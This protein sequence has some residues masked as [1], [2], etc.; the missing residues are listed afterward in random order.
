MGSVNPKLD[1]VMLLIEEALGAHAKGNI[2]RA[3]YLLDEVLKSDPKNTDALNLRGTMSFLQNDFE[4]AAH[5]QSQAVKI[6][7]KAAGYRVNY[8]LTLRRLSKFD[9]AIKQ[10][11]KSI[12]LD[13]ASP[14]GQANL[15][16]LYYEDLSDYEKALPYLRTAVEIN[17]NQIANVRALGACYL[18]LT[19]YP[20]AL[21]L[22][23]R[24]EAEGGEVDANL[25]AGIATAYYFCGDIK[26]T[27]EYAAK[28]L[29]KDKNCTQGHF[30]YACLL[31]DKGRL[32]NCISAFKKCLELEPEKFDARQR[33]LEAMSLEHD[34]DGIAQAIRPWLNDPKFSGHPIVQIIYTKNLINSCQYAEIKNYGNLLRKK[35]A[36]TPDYFANNLS[37]VG[38]VLSDD[39]QTARQLF[40]YQRSWGKLWESRLGK[41]LSP[42]RK[43][44]GKRPRRV[45][46]LSS[47]LR[48]HSVGKFL[49]P[50]YEKVNPA[51]IEFFSYSLS[52]GIN[53]RVHWRFKELSKKFHDLDNQEFEKVAKAIADDDV[54]ILI[55][56]NGMTMGSCLQALAARCAPVQMSWLGYP[57]T[58]G[59][60]DCDYLL[61]D[62]YLAPANGDCMT[63]KPLIL[64]DVSYLCFG[65]A[66]PRNIGDL[67][68]DR[69]GYITFAS[70]NNP[71]KLA[72]YTVDLWRKVLLAVPDS[73]FLYVRPEFEK[74]PKSVENLIASIARD[75]I[76]PSRLILKTN[77]Q[78]HHLDH[79][80]DMDISLDTFPVTGGTTTMDS[81]WMGTPVVSRVGAQIHQRVSN[82]ILN[83]AGLGGLCATT[84]EQY[85][86]IAKNLAADRARLRQWRKTLREDLSK[87]SL[88]DSDKFVRG[89]ANTLLKVE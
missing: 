81:I 13:A 88:I 47:D 3:I 66:S 69:N 11:K 41:N 56:L 57:F 31:M 49:L 25:L 65:A 20:D 40:E 74:Y 10:F 24:A 12:A 14:L 15:G 37:L 2:D 59:L 58:T 43:L 52:Q 75:D 39:D 54:D 38:L 71:Y 78:E 73:K 1:T 53:D 63:E 70:M 48:D 28:C 89:F 86:E 62:R 9:E 60:K 32:A 23:L 7:P 55:E 6:E 72:T 46:I 16:L 30:I 83:F 44:G 29:A 26:P 33:M 50:I 18:A 79:Y 77:Y 27:Q 61:L 80:N 5:F 17:P 8:G 51:E 21:P 34:F 64:D 42:K 4:K 76:D 45:G 87:T 68:A 36:Q 82:S 22:L 84:D 85:V 35:F 19:R 67:P